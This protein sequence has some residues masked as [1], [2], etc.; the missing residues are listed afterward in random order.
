MRQ[1]ETVT[2]GGRFFFL[3]WLVF[4]LYMGYKMSILPLTMPIFTGIFPEK[5][6]ETW[7]A[8]HLYI[9]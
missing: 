2:T 1:K 7:P 9:I 8:P 6:D 3:G 5:K 4:H